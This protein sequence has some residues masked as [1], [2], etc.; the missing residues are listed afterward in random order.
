MSPMLNVG[1]VILSKS[2]NPEEL[3]AGD[4]VTFKGTSGSQK[5]LI[6]THMVEKAPY[7]DETGKT[8]IVTRGVK[9]NSPLDS[10]VAIENVRAVMVQNVEILG[11]IYKIIKTP[12]GFI[13]LIFLPLFLFTI[14]QLY[15]I[16][17]MSAVKKYGKV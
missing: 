4:I 6:I 3:N 9:E 12:G 17:N 7:T 15:K 11:K 2:F 5:G 16:A 14:Y 10:P 13:F 8:Y 1:D